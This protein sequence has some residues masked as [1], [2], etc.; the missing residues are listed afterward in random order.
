MNKTAIQKAF[1]QGRQQ[2]LMEAA[3]KCM[4][5][6]NHY[7]KR[8]VDLYKLEPSEENQDSIRVTCAKQTVALLLEDA[9]RKDSP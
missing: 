5:R 3:M 4:E 8:L 1:E 6:A 9:I 7:R 2:G